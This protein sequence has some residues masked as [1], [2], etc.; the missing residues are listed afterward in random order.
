MVELKKKLNGR[1][2]TQYPF[3]SYCFISHESC[4]P[5]K[6]TDQ[7]LN[8][9]SQASAGRSGLTFKWGESKEGE[10]GGCIPD[11]IVMKPKNGLPLQLS[12]RGQDRGL[13]CIINNREYKRYIHRV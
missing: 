6:K 3:N 9:I 2:A 11:G 4:G 13:S 12:L 10:K 8:P 1:E 5:E 7:Q